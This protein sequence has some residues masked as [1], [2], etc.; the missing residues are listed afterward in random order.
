MTDSYPSFIGQK[1]AEKLVG[2]FGHLKTPKFHSEINWP[3]VSNDQIEWWV[4]Q[5]NSIWLLGRRINSLNVLD[6][7]YYFS[8]KKIN[9]TWLYGLY[10]DSPRSIL[11]SCF[12]ICLYTAI[13]Y[14][15]RTGPD[16]GFHFVLIL[17]GKNLFSLQGTPVLI[18]GIM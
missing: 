12:S 10:H 2:F 1:S 17:T 13:P 9:G 16:Q 11:E 6:L 3:L 18:A 5:M 4:K 14:R 15:A 7:L 8:I